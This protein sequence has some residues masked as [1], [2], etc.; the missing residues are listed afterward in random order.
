[1]SQRRA[2]SK[3]VALF[4]STLTWAS[5]ICQV[6]QADLINSSHTVSRKRNTELFINGEDA[7]ATWGSLQFEVWS[8]PV[9]RPQASSAKKVSDRAGGWELCVSRVKH[10][11][12]IFGDNCGLGAVLHLRL[13]KEEVNPRN[14]SHI[15]PDTRESTVLY[16]QVG[17]EGHVDL[18][19]VWSD[20]V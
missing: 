1:M 7:G 3:T 20:S 6:T 5:C 10:H 18:L 8:S 17:R 4:D 12:D 11:A 14:N 9:G 19:P 2:Y 13:I 15:N 16:L